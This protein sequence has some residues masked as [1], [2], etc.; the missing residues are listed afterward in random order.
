M[1]WQS[2]EWTMNGG[3]ENE[4]VTHDQ[5]C[6]KDPHRKYVM[7]AQKRSLPSANKLCRRMGNDFIHYVI[8]SRGEICVASFI[9][10]SKYWLNCWCSK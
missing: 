10:P 8:L 3:V 9:H 2:S 6:Q 4:T 5:F 7:F 1:N